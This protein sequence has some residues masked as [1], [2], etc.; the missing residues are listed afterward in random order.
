[1]SG[2]AWFHCCDERLP[3]GPGTLIFVEK[4]AEHRFYD[5]SED[6]TVLVLFAPAEGS[7]RT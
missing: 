4:L 7:T 3:V 5:I 1:M 2:R 6:L